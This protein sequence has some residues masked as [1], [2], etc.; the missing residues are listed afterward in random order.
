MPRYILLLLFFSYTL[1]AI[2]QNP[3]SKEIT[4]KGIQL[5]EKQHY[6]KA[7]GM[8]K[9]VNENDSGYNWALANMVKT[10]M[11]MH[12]YDSA[13]II[14]DKGLILKAGNHS[15]LLQMKGIAYN[16]SGNK[17]KAIDV[18]EYAIKKYPFRYLLHYN[19][20][21]IYLSVQNYSKAQ[22][23]FKNALLCNPFD[24][25]SHLQLGKLLARQKQYTRAMLSIETFLSLDPVGSQSHDILVF[26]ENLSNNYVD[27]TE[28]CFIYP[29]ENNSLFEKWDHYL[30]AKIALSTRYPSPIEFNASLVKQT[31]LL[32]DV[33]PLDSIES[34]DFWIR[35]YYPF[36]KKIKDGNFIAPFLYNILRSTNQEE[37]VKYINKHEKDFDAFYE[38]GSALS[39]VKFKRY[40]DIGYGENLYDCSYYDDGNIHA[41]LN[42]TI[43]EKE[44]GPCRYF[45][46]NGEVSAEG[47]FKD[48]LKD[49]LWNYYNQQGDL[50]A[51]EY[52][53]DGLMN[54]PYSSFHSTGK[55]SSMIPYEDGLVN[56]EAEWF[57][58]FGLKT[59]SV[60][61]KKNKKNGDALSFY[62]NGKVHE[63]YQYKDDKLDGN[64][65]SWYDNGKTEEEEYYT[66]DQL[67]GVFKSYYMNGYPAILGNYKDSEEEGKWVSYFI[68]GNVSQVDTFQ[69]GFV[70]G[71]YEEYYHNGDLKETGSYDGKGNRTGISRFYNENG[72]LYLTEK[73]ENNAFVES[74][75]YSKDGKELWKY[76]KKEGLTV[77]KTFYPD[78][79]LMLKGDMRNGKKDGEW[80]R[81]Y[82]NGVVKQ[83]LH[84]T[85]GYLNGD[86]VEYFTNGQV[87]DSMVF[88]DGVLNGP[89]TSYNKAGVHLLKGYYRTGNQNQEWDYY[90]NDGS[91]DHKSYFVD[92]VAQGWSTEYDVEGNVMSRIQYVN[93]K[94][95]RFQNYNSNGEMISDFD[96]TRDSVYLLK[97][98]SIHVTA[99]CEMKGGLYYGDFIWYFPNGSILSKKSF[100][101]DMINGKYERFNELGNVIQTG[102]YLGGEK[103]GIW[104]SFYTDGKIKQVTYYF[105]DEKDSLEIGYFD[106]GNVEFTKQYVSGILNGDVLYYERNGTMLIKYIYDMDELIAYQYAKKNGLSD[107]IRIKEDDKIIAKFKNG[108]KSYTANIKG[109]NLDG[110]CITY[111]PNGME[112]LVENYRCGQLN[113]LSVSY[114]P[115]GN[116]KEECT[117]L[118]G[119]KN[120]LYVS[121]R[122]NGQPAREEHYRNGENHG[123]IKIYNSDGSLSSEADMWSDKVIGYQKYNMVRRKENKKLTAR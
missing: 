10:Y 79:K 62:A 7:L 115:N 23:C 60:N 43:D 33:L 80:T 108:K 50:V 29:V 78:G 102:D 104:S 83:L 101:N 65:V 14:A 31:K 63:K 48:G 41:I 113:G 110:K 84:Y 81:Y 121:Y 71:G 58:E 67:N 3:S 34:D 61:F 89:Y 77:Y 54:G 1:F 99:K 16:Y 45:Y 2:A 18:F 72:V 5:Y 25:D 59:L 118:N 103:Q 47:V 21:L 52:Y 26:L 90:Y 98:D 22:E 32:M 49:S 39:Q 8:F 6:E 75:N 109:Y 97:G 92:G 114:Y 100:S 91:L 93:N 15:H 37:V 35:M 40:T 107:T 120:G 51:K 116:K 24:T 123:K 111:Y 38:T 57:D 36:F 30:K 9:L 19:L 69:N 87:Q 122:E 66:E 86:F 12:K 119:D 55:V 88:K 106:N 11:S 95:T 74:V 94:I 82:K 56:G 76:R 20:G 96:M 27:T 17:K 105:N 44:D 13:I 112:C 68:N 28:G 117:Y 70:V 73:Y 64:Y 53:R 46:P 85:N 42:F 4:D